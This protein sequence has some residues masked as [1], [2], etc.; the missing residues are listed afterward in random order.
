MKKD[1]CLEKRKGGSHI[2]RPPTKTQELTSPKS[3]L[4]SERK[5]FCQD[6]KKWLNSYELPVTQTF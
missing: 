4:E 3:K 5:S 1:V 2:K 6:A